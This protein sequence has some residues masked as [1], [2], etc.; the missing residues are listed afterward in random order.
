MTRIKQ[1]TPNKPA[2]ARD[3]WNMGSIMDVAVNEVIAMR[4]KNKEQGDAI[5]E[6]YRIS[7]GDAFAD[8]LRKRVKARCKQ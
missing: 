6:Q 7:S 1:N 4:A 2:W 5:I 3:A 8:E